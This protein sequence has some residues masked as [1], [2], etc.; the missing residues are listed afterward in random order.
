MHMA[1][2]G[3]APDAVNVLP[4]FSD[5]PAP[6]RRLSR[7]P[8]RPTPQAGGF[9]RS[10]VGWLGFLALASC[11]PAAAPPSTVAPKPPAAAPR[12]P[13]AAPD[14]SQAPDTSRTADTL[15][16]AERTLEGLSL[17]DKVA[18][19][20]MPSVLGNFSPV[21]SRG[22][23]RITRLVEQDHVGG[24]LMS[25]GSPTEVASKLNALQ[26]L[27]KLPLIVSADLETGAGFRFHGA[28]QMPGTIPLGGAT[29]FP[30][31]MAVGATGD[32]HLAY[33][34]GAITAEEGRA[35]GVQIPFAPVLDVND[36]PKN[37]IINVRSF[38][39][40]PNEVGRLG[41]AFVRGMQDHGVIATGKHFPGHGDTNIDTHLA[42]PVIHFDRAH[43][44][45]IELKP[46]QMAIDSGIGAIMSAH[47]A[48]PA[49][50]GGTDDPATLSKDVLTGLLRNQ[51]GFRG[52]VFT[53][54]MDMGAITRRYPGGEAA[55]RAVLA[56]ADV[57]IQPLSTETDLDAIVEAVENGR[58][59]ES[60]VDS[61]VLRIL[62]AKHELGLDR[63]RTVDLEAIPSV[64][65]IPAHQEVAAEIARKSITLLRNRKHLLPLRGT[66]SARVLSITY[67]RP[68]DV[69]AGRYFDGRLR[70]TYPR[71]V[72]VDLNEDT[73]AAVYSGLVRQA[74]RSALVV[75]STYV[76]AVSY[77]GSVALPKET[78]RFIERLHRLGVPHIVVTFG[79]PYLISEFP[80]VQA[81]MLAWSG[82]RESQVAAADALF[83]AFPIQGHTPTAIP[84]FYHIGDGMM[85]PAR[86]GVS[87]D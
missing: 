21:G 11:G 60:V 86:P 48:V 50:N 70:A 54:A 8:Y 67:R 37:P 2:I 9:A 66:R 59:P 38:G 30:Y 56:G 23:D 15:S 34:M 19:M 52:L 29:E 71:L 61:A 33:E 46:F 20:L 31:L 6:G 57:L 87:G 73:P 80:D 79:N 3:V 12:R 41:C 24:I 40:D 49:L 1:S 84:P 7:M 32:A 62:R 74:R 76:T 16:W 65:G 25:V 4:T 17:R 64:V 44:D 10:V 82:S 78:S 77:H 58:I 43:L 22:W 39:G 51:M 28:I 27:S 47:I 75:V 83:G 55:V 26:K 85:I 13:A 14:T 36:N 35:I 81:Y 5:L 18:Q 42:L 45:S 68:S 69:L 72:T 53:D 63:K